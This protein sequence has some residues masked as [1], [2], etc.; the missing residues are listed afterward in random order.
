MDEL[1]YHPAR[2]V[3]SKGGELERMIPMSIARLL[4]SAVA[5]AVTVAALTVAPFAGA[6][7]DVFLQVDGMQGESTDREFRDAIVVTD[8]A[9]GLSNGSVTT[10][11]SSGGRVSF[12]VLTLTK[13]VDRASPKLF[14]AAASGQAFPSATISTRKSGGQP[15]STF[16]RIKLSDVTVTSLKVQ[17]GNELVEHVSLGFGKIEI[18]YFMQEPNGKVMSTGKVAWDVR[19]NTKG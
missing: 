15:Q 18:E 10:G 3:S 2:R 4:R 17:E 7:N 12:D 1:V 6:A 11:G 8:F 13:R 9:F 14:L 19:R 5:S 16:Y